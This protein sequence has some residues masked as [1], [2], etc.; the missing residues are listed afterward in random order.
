MACWLLYVFLNS[1]WQK[2][3]SVGLSLYSTIWLRYCVCVLRGCRWLPFTPVFVFWQRLVCFV[4]DQ[5]W[6]GATNT[7]FLAEKQQREVTAM[8][9][10]R[11][12]QPFPFQSGIA[13]RIST[14][15]RTHSRTHAPTDRHLPQERFIALHRISSPACVSDRNADLPVYFSPRQWVL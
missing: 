12:R 15:A 8:S 2:N 9:F 14:H 1:I 4:P 11:C 3:D 10:K 7:T 13:W 6:E 5:T